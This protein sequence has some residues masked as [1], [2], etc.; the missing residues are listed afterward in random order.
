MTVVAIAGGGAASIPLPAILSLQ[1]ESEALSTACTAERAFTDQQQQ[2]QKGAKHRKNPSRSTRVALSRQR[3]QCRTTATSD[4]WMCLCRPQSLHGFG[5]SGFL[6]RGSA[7]IFAGL[8]DP[9]VQS[10]EDKYPR[11]VLVTEPENRRMRPTP[12]PF[13]PP[14]PRKYCPG[15]GSAQRSHRSQSLRLIF[16]SLR[17]TPLSMVPWRRYRRHSHWRHPRP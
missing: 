4:P 17:R 7:D 10:H 12:P 11:R 16:R 2:S 9:A 14:P 1:S 15:R 13:P 6:G 8:R 3:S 5:P